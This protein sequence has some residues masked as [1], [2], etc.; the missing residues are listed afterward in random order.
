MNWFGGNSVG[1][2]PSL[3]LTPGPSRELE[4]NFTAHDSILQ[5]GHLGHRVIHPLSWTNFQQRRL[6]LNVCLRQGPLEYKMIITLGRG[7]ENLKNKGFLAVLDFRAFGHWEQHGSFARAGEDLSQTSIGCSKS[8]GIRQ[9]ENGAL[10][11]LDCITMGLTLPSLKACPSNLKT[12]GH[13]GMPCGSYSYP[14]TRKTKA[15][16]LLWGLG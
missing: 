4:L 6:L 9:W 8:I 1:T 12:Q 10:F 15:G 3:T 13:N 14:S 5:T 16:G 7:A 2:L 11:S